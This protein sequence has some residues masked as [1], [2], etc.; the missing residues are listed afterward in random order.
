MKTL[1]NVVS[2]E[3]TS[4]TETPAGRSLLA[5]YGMLACCLVML[6]PVRV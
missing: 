4:P 6:L 2:R 5:R 1:L 3:T